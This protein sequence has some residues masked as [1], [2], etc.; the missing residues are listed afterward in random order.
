[1]TVRVRAALGLLVASLL[2]F[3][4]AGWIHAKGLL[5]QLLL[6]RSWSR[7]ERHEVAPPLP[8][9]G[10]RTRP[11]ARLLVPELAVDRLV[12]DGVEL[13]KLAWG[14]GLVSGRDDHHVIA[15][16]RD[17][18]FRFLGDLQIGDGVQMALAPGP[19][20]EAGRPART[21]WVVAGSTVIDSRTSRIDLDAPGPLLTMVTCYPLDAEFAGTPL[22]LVVTALPQRSAARSQEEIDPTAGIVL[23]AGS[24][25][26]RFGRLR[27]EGVLSW[28]P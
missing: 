26:S 7:A 11:A 19:N 10:A 1:M 17:T 21:D 20:R 3:G 5:G 14:P 12:L 18:H 22:R 13:P 27:D 24:G 2:L 15:G 28:Q 16:H 25:E 8:W 6:E 9:P 23:A 4:H